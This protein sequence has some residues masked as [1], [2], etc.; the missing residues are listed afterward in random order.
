MSDVA[1]KSADTALLSKRSLEQ[2][3]PSGV[4]V[5]RQD[6]LDGQREERR[7]PR[8]VVGTRLSLGKPVVR[9]RPAREGVAE[10]ERRTRRA[11]GRS[12]LG[13]S[14]AV[15]RRRS[16]VSRAR[17]NSERATDT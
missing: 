4:A 17:A 2:I 5:R 10:Y 11:T 6:E 14:R 7:E 13:R 9:Y 16:R 12:R 1:V 15:R 8:A 3:T